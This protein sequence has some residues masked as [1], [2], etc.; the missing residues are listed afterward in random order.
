M[1]ILI[2]FYRMPR[3]LKLVCFVLIVNFQLLAAEETRDDFIE[4]YKCSSLDPYCKNR[5]TDTM[6]TTVKCPKDTKCSLRVSSNDS[7]CNYLDYFKK[8]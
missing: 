7:N 6:V 3:V 5:V 4:C 8:I 2:L 1:T